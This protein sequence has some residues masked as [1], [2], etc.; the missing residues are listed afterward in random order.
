MKMSKAIRARESILERKS[1]S[2]VSSVS[3]TSSSYIAFL[4]KK[5]NP[6]A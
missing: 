2:L 4:I 5:M 3:L 6:T 1:V